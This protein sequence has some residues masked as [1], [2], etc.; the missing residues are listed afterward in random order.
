V[1]CLTVAMGCDRQDQSTQPAAQT[2]MDQRVKRLR[3]DSKIE[4]QNLRGQWIAAEG[5]LTKH[6]DKI[7]DLKKNFRKQVLRFEKQL[8]T[9]DSRITALDA[10]I[11]SLT[12]MLQQLAAP[13]DTLED[14]LARSYEEIYCLRKQ[15][16]EEAVAAV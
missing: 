12:Q 9:M 13:K 14:R 5:M 4:V 16:K 10:N 8:K 11:A 1:V 6:R 2:E 3:D 15:G 7:A